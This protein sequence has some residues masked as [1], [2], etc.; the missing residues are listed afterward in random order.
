MRDPTYLAF[1]LKYIIY[2]IMLLPPIEFHITKNFILQIS[3]KY[4]L[5][6]SS[7]PHLTTTHIRQLYPM[8]FIYIICHPISIIIHTLPILFVL[9]IHLLNNL[10]RLFHTLQYIIIT[11]SPPDYPPKFD[12][13]CFSF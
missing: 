5:H 13:P 10:I 9:S 7:T 3:T 4:P 12:L 11:H 6:S 8:L 2:Y 1:Q